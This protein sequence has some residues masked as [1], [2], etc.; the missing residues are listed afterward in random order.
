MLFRSNNAYGD[1][2]PKF[3]PNGTQ[4][5]YMTY[6]RGRWEIAIMAYPGGGQVALYDCPDPA[7]RFPA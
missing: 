2:A 5:A 1:R 6:Q 3:S 7:C 4:I